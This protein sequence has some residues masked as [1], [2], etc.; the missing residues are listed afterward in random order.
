LDNIISIAVVF[1]LIRQ[2]YKFDC[3]FLTRE[4]Y[5]AAHPQIIDYLKKYDDISDRKTQYKMI[6]LDI[7]VGDGQGPEIE[8]GVVT[9]PFTSC[10]ELL[11]KD[12]I[13]S[14]EE[15]AN[16]HKIPWT[17]FN[18][19]AIEQAGAYLQTNPVN[20]QIVYV[21]MPLTEYH[22]PNE[23][24][25]WDTVMHTIKLL[26]VYLNSVGVTPSKK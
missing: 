14:L 22:S 25:V 4:E 7:D 20:K 15:L 26:Q 23:T 9:L 2:G 1:Y 19:R 17:R 24:M 12:M 16:S 10:G 5:M 6:S 3:L 11:D 8:R 18:R 21:G 13:R